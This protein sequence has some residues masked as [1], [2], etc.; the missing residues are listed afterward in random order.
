M[1]AV[2]LTRNSIRKAE[3]EYHGK[4]GH[5][6]YRIQNIYILIRIYIYYTACRLVTQNVVPTLPGFQGLKHRI[7]HLASHPH[8]PIFYTSNYHDVSNYIRLKNRGNQFEEY[9]TNNYI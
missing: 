7:Q 2:S 8:K 9:I 3:M 5:T 1:A 4:F 6:I